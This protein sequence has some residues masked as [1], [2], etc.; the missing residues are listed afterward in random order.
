MLVSELLQKSR[1]RIEKGWTQSAFYRNQE[2]HPCP[3]DE[4]VSYCLLGALR[5]TVKI[6][7]PSKDIVVSK[8]EWK[9][10]MD[11]IEEDVRPLQGATRCLSQNLGVRDDGG[12]TEWNDTKGRTKEEVLAA[13]DQAIAKAME[14]EKAPPSVASTT[15][16][17]PAQT[18]VKDA[19]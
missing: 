11:S 7:Y 18:E 3:A 15:I 1:E 5:S 13:L 10:I 4:A 2:G 19:D 8:D 12:I 14:E 6:T 9:R 17:A 16:D